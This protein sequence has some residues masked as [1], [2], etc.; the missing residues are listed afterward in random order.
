MDEDSN[1][2]PEW[3]YNPNLM[4]ILHRNSDCS[5]CSKYLLHVALAFAE[6][7]P[8]W[9]KAD[10][11]R[12]KHLNEKFGSGES[13]ADTASKDLKI[14]ELTGSYNTLKA[15]YD[16]ICKDH[17]QITE[18]RAHY[19]SRS[20]KLDEELNELS[21]TLH[22]RDHDIRVLQRELNELKGR[23][24]E[25]LHKRRRTDNLLEPGPSSYDPSSATDRS[26]SPIGFILTPSE[27]AQ[28]QPSQSFSQSDDS[29]VRR[30]RPPTEPVT[31]AQ[32]DDY[33][34]MLR[35]SEQ[36]H[37]KPAWPIY[38]M[39]EQ[40][41]YRALALPESE[42]SAVHQSV[43]T[44][45]YTPGFV[46]EYYNHQPSVIDSTRTR[47][48]EHRSRQEAHCARQEAEHAAAVQRKADIKPPSL[49][50]PDDTIVRWLCQSTIEK[51]RKIAG[52]LTRASDN[53]VSLRSIR[54]R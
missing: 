41:R 35:S 10:A 9:D 38:R 33:F 14:S 20:H 15:S 23:G 29:A 17:A 24:G 13:V 40:L 28:F 2:S 34:R 4:C 45:F 36:P 32:V 44:Q 30:R 39:L 26:E 47:P 49:N 16:Q 25:L 37:R 7:N 53:H 8:S 52:I 21:D 31:L 22:S 5:D 18:E 3:R 6:A 43:I 19:R 46:S 27:A 48:D 50:A 11:E 51:P 42:R 1:P 12:S 54:G